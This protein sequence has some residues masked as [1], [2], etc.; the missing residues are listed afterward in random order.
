MTTMG[1]LL[2]FLFSKTD[3]VDSDTADVNAAFPTI[4]VFFSSKKPTPVKPTNK[5]FDSLYTNKK[6]PKKE[7]ERE[8]LDG[9]GRPDKRCRDGI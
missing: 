6:N 2:F 1:F 8:K 3:E 9:G 4:P 7:R 5:S